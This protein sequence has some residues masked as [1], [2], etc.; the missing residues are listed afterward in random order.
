M[1]NEGGVAYWA[2]IVL[3]A[4]GLVVAIVLIAC[5]TQCFRMTA[6]RLRERRAPRISRWAERVPTE[7]HAFDGPLPPTLPR[8][9]VSELEAFEQDVP[10]MVADIE[11]DSATG[12][13]LP[14]D[15][16]VPPDVASWL[17]QHADFTAYVSGDWSEVAS[18]SMPPAAS[19][20]LFSARFV[21]G[22]SEREGEA[23]SATESVVSSGTKASSTWELASNCGSEWHGH[24]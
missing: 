9:P 12:S 18:I 8:S 4:L 1:Q 2:S 10:G 13:I 14:F 16:H 23:G 20:V 7:E 11:G 24:E 5:V 15:A 22:R 21:Y 19:N 17:S 3:F 6:N